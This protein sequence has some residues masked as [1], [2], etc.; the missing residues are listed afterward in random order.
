MKWKGRKQSSNI[1]DRRGGGPR[2]G[3]PIGGGFGVIL[4]ILYLLFGGGNLGSL[5]ST[6]TG[7]APAQTQY[8]ES[9][10]EQEVREFAAV[11]LQDLEDVW[12]DIFAQY[13]RTYEPPTLVLYTGQ[14]QTACGIGDARS[15]PFYCPGD[16]K[17]YLDLQFA[18]QL[19]R[20]LGAPGDFAF[21]YVLAHE[22]G[23]HVQTLLG[24]TDKVMPLRNQMSER[25]FNQYLQRFELQADYFA[26]VFAHHIKEK[27]YLEEGDIEEA[28]NG[29]A[30]VGDDRLQERAQGYV[31]PD[32]FTHGTS[33]ERVYWFTKG[34][35]EGTIEGGDTF[36]E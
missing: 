2:I 26:G 6:D 21:A 19:E 9:R 33:R 31:V 18:N 29:A 22:T 3:L 5:P 14:T 13:G 23:H 16:R 4:L 27:G 1:E 10:S 32:T 28:M 35:E 12:T 15:G 8:Q 36:R 7:Q 34:Y 11:V 24:V 25:E 20:Q 30:A 17:I